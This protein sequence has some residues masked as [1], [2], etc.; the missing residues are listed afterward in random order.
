MSTFGKPASCEGCPAYAWEGF[1]RPDQPEGAGLGVLLLGEALGEQEAKT[2][3]PF[4][5]RAGQVFG[6]LL[7][8]AGFS[9]DQFIIANSVWCRPPKNK[10]EGA[11]YE[12][13]VVNACATRH[14]LPLVQR[15]TPKVIFPMGNV[16]P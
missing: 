9:R 14:L 7:Q 13:P 15:T 4:Q 8:H 6:K 5:G 12:F 2:G 16:P 1:M 3:R 10:L 11:P